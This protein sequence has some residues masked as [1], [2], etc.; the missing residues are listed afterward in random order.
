[1]TKQDG[2][3]D[4]WVEIL[5]VIQCPWVNIMDNVRMSLGKHKEG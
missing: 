4:G 1:M 3:E 5:V 2:V